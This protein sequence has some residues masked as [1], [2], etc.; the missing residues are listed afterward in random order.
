MNLEFLGCIN[1][2]VAVG[3]F[4]GMLYLMLNYRKSIVLKNFINTLSPDLIEIYQDVSYE[5]MTIYIQGMVLGLVLGLIYLNYAKQTKVN[6]ACTFTVI[7]LG[8][9]Y[10]YYIL[11]PKSRYMVPLLETQEQREAWIKVYRE[12][13]YRCKAG[14]VLGLLTYFFVGY[15]V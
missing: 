14:F 10:L 6:R 2:L 4:S 12:M 7:I 9:N 15:F 13:Q 5:R 8:I 3:M 1:C 11:M